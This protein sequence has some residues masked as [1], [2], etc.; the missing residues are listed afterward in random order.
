[1]HKDGHYED[2]R[3]FFHFVNT[4]KTSVWLPQ[5]AGAVSNG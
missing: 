3:L 1:M 5:V 4:P 2:N